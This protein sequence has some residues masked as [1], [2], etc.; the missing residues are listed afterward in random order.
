MSYLYSYRLETQ[1][2][3][4]LFASPHQ[5]SSVAAPLGSKF[6]Q[7]IVLDHFYELGKGS[8]VWLLED[9]LSAKLVVCTADGYLQRWSRTSSSRI[10]ESFWKI[11][12]TFDS[13]VRFSYLLEEEVSLYGVPQINPQ[14]TRSASASSL[15]SASRRVSTELPVRHENGSDEPPQTPREFVI[16]SIEVIV[17]ERVAGFVTSDG[18][19]A[20]LQGDLKEFESL[21]CI[22]LPLQS[23]AAVNSSKS[24]PP[25]STGA[26]ATGIALNTRFHTIA[27]GLSNGEVELYSFLHSFRCER[28]LSLA[29]WAITAKETGYAATLSWT[30]D[31]R[32]LAVGYSQRGL[33]TWSL[34]GCRLACTIVQSHVLAG[35][36]NSA[37]TEAAG[38]GVTRLHW[39]LDGYSLFFVG[40]QKPCP[41]EELTLVKTSLATN[42]NLNYCQRI[43]LQ[44]SDKLHLLN[45]S[46]GHT[47]PEM[48]RKWIQMPVPSAYSA[49]NWPI[50]LVSMSHDGVLAAVSGSRGF[51]FANL[52]TGKWRIFG[53]SGEEQQ[54]NISGLCWFKHV[55]VATN[56]INL[57]TGAKY[58]LL[59]FPSWTKLS[60]QGILC[61][62]PLPQNRRPLYVDCNDSFLVIFTTDAFFYQYKISFEASK[63]RPSEIVSIS[64]RQ[65]QQVSVGRAAASPSSM[66]LL[67]ASVHISSS[68]ELSS[69]TKTPQAAAKC[70]VLDS[71][72]DL[73]LQNAERSIHLTLAQGV[74]QFWMANPASNASDQDLSNTLWAYGSFGLEVWFPFFQTTEIGRS[75]GQSTSVAPM[76]FLSRDSSLEFDLEVYPIGFLPHSAVIV[77]VSQ[78]YSTPV[79]TFS[80]HGPVFELQTKTHPFLHSI[81]RRMIE[82]EHGSESALSM[83]R[84]Y[85]NVPHYN[86]SL[87]LLLHE[88]LEDEYLVL[89]RALK[90]NPLPSS[91]ANHVPIGAGLTLKRV[92]GLLR[93]LGGRLYAPLVV[94]C[95]RKT[96]PA[97]W[98]LLFHPTFGAD[99]PKHLFDICVSNGD[100]VSAASYLRVL[101]LHD[102][103]SAARRAGVTVVELCLKGGNWAL[104]HDLF[105]FLEP[106]ASEAA[107]VQVSEDPSY[108]E[109]A[110]PSPRQDSSTS[111]M[112][113]QY[114][115][116]A[117]PLSGPSPLSRRNSTSLL[118]MKADSD[119]DDEF[120]LERVL[121]RYSRDLLSSLKIRDLVSFSRFCRRPPRYW[122]MRERKRGA[123]VHDYNVALNTL[124]E[125]FRVPHPPYAPIDLLIQ[126]QRSS[127]RTALDE[128]DDDDPAPESRLS[129]SG[130][131]LK[132]SSRRFAEYNV[133]Y[134]PGSDFLLRRPKSAS[135]SREIQMDQAD[136]LEGSMSL[137][138]PSP[139]FADAE[140]AMQAA[141]CDL[142]YLLEEFLAAECLGWTLL[143]ATILF[144]VKLVAQLLRRNISSWKLYR[145]MLQAQAETCKGYADLLAY[146]ESQ[147]H[148]DP[149]KLT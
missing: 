118:E 24:A 116:F 62:V 15:A 37:A 19:A 138:P 86:Q 114:S 103:D 32:A 69:S 77:G 28:T 76:T 132:A 135:A 14:R 141:F 47:S 46:L 149:V 9:R 64:V 111:S 45:R 7:D 110:P 67:P 74:E 79:G 99:P 123:I 84:K 31:G 16:K 121:A 40:P 148:S 27:V 55:L 93:Q 75:T 18:R 85:W 143:V 51:C 30:Y 70:V 126:M 109:S 97:L 48:D 92:V 66:L 115:T 119:G 120:L 63:T 12:G 125:Q 72:G 39:S 54:L 98:A 38:S 29:P 52:N 105:R 134:Y 90:S 144:R 82:K 137:E 104:L 140:S 146:Y 59:F 127:S 41:L 61:R 53:D 117:S 106:D 34:S 73:S 1:R 4:D 2:D 42:P 23:G 5:E 100:I 130:F 102:G 60:L 112:Q 13:Q 81:L 71:S 122:F 22:W 50:R 56:S 35:S 8:I 96:D 49:Q 25:L 142:E 87:E 26:F 108:D 21:Q 11:T 101:Q 128:V 57:P 58:E 124:H 68:S 89:G 94:A 78:S 113:E 131:E 129:G 44:G 133:V 139:R 91:D 6:R 88:V 145:P 3:H 20:I 10:V 95:A 36:L 136:E 17:K 107:L 33:S 43:L 83:A 80:T 65:V 147:F